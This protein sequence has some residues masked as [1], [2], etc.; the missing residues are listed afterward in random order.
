MQ[1]NKQDFF[2]EL[3]TSMVLKLYELGR[4][5]SGIAAE[6][7]DMSRKDFI[8]SLYKYK[9]PVINYETDELLEDI[10]NA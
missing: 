6:I 10:K 2:I 1:V 3:K 9:I 4:I 8:L 7:L 5:S